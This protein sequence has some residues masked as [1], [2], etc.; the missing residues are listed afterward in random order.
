MSEMSKMR[1]MADGRWPMF[2]DMLHEI[3]GP[4]WAI[5]MAAALPFRP[6]PPSLP[7][8]GEAGDSGRRDEISRWLARSCLSRS[9]LAALLLLWR[10]HRRDRFL[11]FLLL[12][13]YCC[14]KVQYSNYLT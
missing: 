12:L 3:D 1:A 6:G 10:C 13:Y 7:S 14:H 5:F 2:P 4:C 8:K 11:A 9:G